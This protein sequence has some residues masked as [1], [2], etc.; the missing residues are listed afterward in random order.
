MIKLH[1]NV[2]SRRRRASGSPTIS[3]SSDVRRLR[4]RSTTTSVSVSRTLSKLRTRLDTRANANP[5]D[6]TSTT[7]VIRLR[8][9]VTSLGTRLSSH[10]DRSV[11]VTTSF[12][13]CHGHADGR[14]RRLRDRIA[15]GAIIRLLPI[16]S[17]FRQ[18]QSRVGPRARN[19]VTV[20]GDC[21]KIC[22]RLMRTLGQLKISTVQTR[23]RRFSPVLRRTI[24][25]R[26]ATRRPRKAI[27]R[28]FIQNCR[29]NSQIL[30]RT[31]I[32]ITTPPRTSRTTKTRRRTTSND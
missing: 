10:T 7:I 16:M 29:L 8:R 26:P 13:G 19:R 1:D 3:R 4:R 9:R 24:V 18:T 31:V 6:T 2:I 15:K 32:G 11:Q 5:D 21:R 20:R 27:V 28:R 30:H 14:G 22:G 12:R 23:N 25:Q 17:G